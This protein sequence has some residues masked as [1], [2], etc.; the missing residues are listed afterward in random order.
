MIT[1]K[2]L[3]VS[4]KTNLSLFL[5]FFL[6]YFKHSIDFYNKVDVN[7]IREYYNH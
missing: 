4:V 1:K 5:K 7:I 3:K 2:K 6:K